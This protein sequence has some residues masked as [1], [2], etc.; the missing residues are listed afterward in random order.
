MIGRGAQG[1][2]WIFREV[3]HFLKTGDLLAPPSLQEQHAVLKEHVAAVHDFYGDEQGVRIARKH[4]GWYLSEH[5]KE[6]QFRK[7]FNAL[8]LTCEQLSAI[9]DY[10]SALQSGESRQISPAA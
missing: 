6:R 5:D 1:N 4:V 9:D 2:P 8:E 7:T 10:F 3:D